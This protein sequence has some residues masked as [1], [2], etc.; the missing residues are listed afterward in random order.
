[1]YKRIMLWYQQGLWTAAMVET[2]AQ[3]GII[4]AEQAAEIINS[5]EV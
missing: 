3:K 4:T 5:K 2:A 1:M